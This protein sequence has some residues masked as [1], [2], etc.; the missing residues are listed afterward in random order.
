MQ[1][2]DENS[3]SASAHNSRLRLQ[4]KRHYMPKYKGRLKQIQTASVI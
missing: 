2:T 4:Q 3:R 1:R